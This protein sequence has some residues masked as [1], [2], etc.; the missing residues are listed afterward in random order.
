MY[1]LGITYLAHSLRKAGRRAYLAD[2]LYDGERLE[3]LIQEIEPDLIGLSLRNIDSTQSGDKSVFFVPDFVE[4]VARIRRVS[5]KPIVI[6]G[7]AF[8]LFPSELLSMSGADYGIQ[9]EGEKSL[10]LLIDA[11]SRGS[12]PTDVP[13]AVYRKNGQVIAATPAHERE[14]RVAPCYRDDLLAYYMRESGAIN[15]QSQRG[16]SFR[17]CYC[18]Y[19]LIEGRRFR[20]RPAEEI[21]DELAMAQDR[22]ARYFFIVDS[23]FNS[24]ADHVAN[25]CEAMLHRNLRLRWGCFLR[26]AGVSEALAKLM[27][28]AG[29]RHVEFGSDSLCDETLEAYGKDFT[30]ADIV[31]THENVVNSGAYAAHFTI[32]GGPAETEQTLRQSFENARTFRKALFFPFVGMRIYPNTPLWQR[33]VEEKVISADQDLLPP[34]FYVS[35]SL[36]ENRI[37]DL[38]RRF[39]KMDRRWIVDGPDTTALER[40]ADLRARGAVGPLWEFLLY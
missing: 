22:G 37:N 33:A 8:S 25:I 19:P 17:C 1:P 10:L 20:R 9:G 23:I 6:G 30:V 40:I 24:S 32:A 34:A 36:S 14:L 29:L 16:C 4:A 27:V 39:Q 31:R 3:S 2:S 11:L 7:S 28:R 26:P 12:E 13:G 18:T 35:P 21:V 38:L 5:A 15:V